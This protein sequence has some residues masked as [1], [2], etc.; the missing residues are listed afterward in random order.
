M[1]G[2]MDNII[3]NPAEIEKTEKF[4]TNVATTLKEIYEARISDL[5]E[6]IFTLKRDRRILAVTAGILMAFVIIL[7]VF[8]LSLGSHGWVEY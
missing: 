5:K 6:Q 1:G 8:D 7:L 3:E 4:E 2:S